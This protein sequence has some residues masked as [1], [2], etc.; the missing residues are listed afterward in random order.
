MRM[1]TAAAWAWTVLILVACWLPGRWLHVD[2]S[3]RH[4]MP[5]LDKVVHGML[6]AGFGFLWLRALRARGR[7]ARVLAIGLAL[8]VLTELGQATAFIA[9]DA[10]PLDALA[11]AA[12]LLLGLGAAWFGLPA[13]TD[14]VQ[15]GTDA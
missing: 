12:G 10:D 15:C 11:D 2:E 8:A 9:R 5:H 3:P 4:G 6:F 1:R 14:E 7:T 13:P